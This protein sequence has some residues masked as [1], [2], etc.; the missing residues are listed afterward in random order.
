MEVVAEGGSRLGPVVEFERKW[1]MQLSYCCNPFGFHE[2][3][4]FFPSLALS[5]PLIKHELKWKELWSICFSAAVI[6]FYELK[7]GN[8]CG[9]LQYDLSPV[10]KRISAWPNAAN[11]VAGKIAVVSVAEILVVHFTQAVT[12]RFGSKFP[13]SDFLEK[14]GKL[15]FKWIL[16]GKFPVAGCRPFWQAQRF[17]YFVAFM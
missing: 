15:K 6:P 7:I 10:W 8:F 12:A 14:S 4:S 16:K 9:C 17:S 1:A 2:P 11:G 13:F 5:R 3:R